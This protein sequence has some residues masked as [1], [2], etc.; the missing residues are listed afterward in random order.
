MSQKY[1]KYKIF[2]FKDKLDSLPAENP[3]V[4]APVHIRI[5][6][7][8]RCNHNCWYC[9]YRSE[10]LQLG[11]DMNVKDMIPRKKMLEIIEDCAEMGVKAITFSGGGEPFSYPYFED[12]L[13]ALSETDIRFAALT[14]GSMLKGKPAEY[15]AHYASWLRISVDGWDDKSYSEYRSVKEGEF[16]KLIKNI[17]EFKKLNG[18]CFLGLSFII[19]N[20]NYRHIYDFASQ[21]KDLGADSIKLSPCIVSNSGAENNEYHSSIFNEAKAECLKVKNTLEDDS[22]EVFEAYHTQLESFSKSYNWC[23][24]LQILPVIGA[25]QNVY[26][27]QDKAYNISEAL[28]GSIK[29]IRFKDFWFSD[30]DKFF[31]INP[32]HVCSHHCVANEKNRMILEYLDA[33]REHLRFV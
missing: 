3:A 2:H 21:M 18:R 23:P 4:L 30:K 29:D 16:S 5:K 13:K 6:P 25:D 9:A 26:P 28:I 22:F 20:K 14:N 27:C 12:V 32:S 24:F 11:Q 33:D 31:K 1:T 10:N 19:D 8:N 15:F 7:T 17:S